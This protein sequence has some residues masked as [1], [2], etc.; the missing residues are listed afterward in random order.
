MTLIAHGYKKLVGQYYRNLKI[1]EK[2]ND[3]ERYDRIYHQR[4]KVEGHHGHVK[5][6]L[7]MEVA[8]N[9]R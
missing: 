9:R 7:L 8:M 6:N 2:E 4:S 1:K 5:V 3:P